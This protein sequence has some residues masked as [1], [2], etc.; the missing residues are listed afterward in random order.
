VVF[1]EEME[2]LV[3]PFVLMTIAKLATLLKTANGVETKQQ[4]VNNVLNSE[5]D[6]ELVHLVFLLLTTVQIS[7]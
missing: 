7:N 3:G 2:L 4:E 5:L 1:V 6:Q